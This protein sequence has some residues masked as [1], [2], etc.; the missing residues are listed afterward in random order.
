MGR[1]A[2]PEVR[3]GDH[4]RVVIAVVPQQPQLHVLGKQARE[5]AQH[6]FAQE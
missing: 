4:L 6:T 2:E 5:Q 1:I 3:I